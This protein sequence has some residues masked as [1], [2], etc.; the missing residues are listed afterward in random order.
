MRIAQVAPLYESVPPALYGG[1]E[2]VVS[3]LTEELGHLGHDVALFARGGSKTAAHLVPPC[4]KPLCR[5]TECR[6][7]LPHHV[8]MFEL[9]FRDASRFDIIHFHCDYIHFP[10]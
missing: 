7:T 3:W 5:D 1:S 6:S 10:L 8:R 4:E 2:R 9:V